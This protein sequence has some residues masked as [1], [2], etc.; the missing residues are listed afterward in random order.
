VGIVVIIRCPFRVLLPLL[1]GI[2]LLG[3]GAGMS[4]LW[5]YANSPGRAGKALH[6]WPPEIDRA[7][8]RAS[9]VFFVHPHCPCSRASVRELA[10]ITARCQ[11]GLDARVLFVEPAGLSREWTRTDL[12]YEASA[13]PGVEVITDHGGASAR[14]F[15][16]ETSGHGLLYGAGGDLLFSGGI[17]AARGHSGDNRGRSTIISLLTDQTATALGRAGPVQTFVFG[18][19]LLDRLGD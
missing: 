3:V 7:P 16:V 18:C 13:I 14:R 19:P 2:W 5:G 4:V 17:T 1:A 10:L 15:G 6:R 12:W 8:G 11:G 9:L